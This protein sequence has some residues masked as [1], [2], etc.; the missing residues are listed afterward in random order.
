MRDQ[1][2]MPYTTIFFFDQDRWYDTH[3]KR[4]QKPFDLYSLLQITD[5]LIYRDSLTNP[6][7]A[8]PREAFHTK[9]VIFLGVRQTEVAALMKDVSNS[10][11]EVDS[12]I[13]NTYFYKSA[14]LINQINEALQQ[15]ESTTQHDDFALLQ[16]KRNRFTHIV[17]SPSSIATK[18]Q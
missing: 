16:E 15:L 10:T 12:I 17:N 1:S 11:V 4:E 18:L 7:K 9:L 14:L 3:M 13:D 6:K 8:S 5:S 2:I